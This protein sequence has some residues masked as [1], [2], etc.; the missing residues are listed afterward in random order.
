MKFLRELL[1]NNSHELR[2]VE[3]Q[4]RTAYGKKELISQIKEKEAMKK[5]EK[6]REYNND[7]KIIEA[8]NNAKKAEIELQ[9]RKNELKLEYKKAISDQL[10]N[11]A[12]KRQ[13]ISS[14]YPLV[15]FGHPVKDNLKTNCFKF[16][17][18]EFKRINSQLKDKEREL[19]NKTDK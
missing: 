7:L 13:K 6:V 18:D 9:T 11:I 16:D 14:P 4:L 1:R 17:I 3:R 5:E 19:S 2:C 8:D 15:E 12:E 10:Q